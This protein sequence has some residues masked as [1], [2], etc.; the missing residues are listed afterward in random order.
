LTDDR[1]N[2]IQDMLAEL[3]RIVGNTNAVAEELRTD[4][5]ELKADVTEL[6][7]GQQRLE[8]NQQILLENQ[9][10]LEENLAQFKKETDENFED[11]NEKMDYTLLKLAK[12]EVK[13]L[14]KKKLT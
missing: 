6:K 4:V 9:Q 3:I 2:Q 12:H 8:K 14:A 10:T 1:L 11:L 13:L 7:A 5:T